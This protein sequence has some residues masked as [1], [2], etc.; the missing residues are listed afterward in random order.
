MKPP[1]QHWRTA[2]GQATVSSLPLHRWLLQARMRRGRR[3]QTAEPLTSFRAV[4]NPVLSSKTRYG[5]SA[6]RS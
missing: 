2:G 6:L 5:G 1:G 3:L 4:R